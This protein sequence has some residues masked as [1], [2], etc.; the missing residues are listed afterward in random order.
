M[1]YSSPCIYHA[2]YL[3][4]YLFTWLLINLPIFCIPTY[5]SIFIPIFWLIYPFSHL[6]T[7][8]P[9]YYSVPPVTA[10]D[11]SGEVTQTFHWLALV[12]ISLNKIISIYSNVKCRIVVY[13]IILFY[14][15]P[16]TLMS[17]FYFSLCVYLFMYF[18][19]N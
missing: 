16:V 5:L 11:D 6:S 4:I 19:S 14:F 8:P 1:T 17:L 2:P 7:Y 12:S 3:S 18:S 13:V 9:M 15:V 10:E